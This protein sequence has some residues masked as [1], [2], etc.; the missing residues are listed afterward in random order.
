MYSDAKMN[1]VSQISKEIEQVYGIPKT[2]T[3]ML[4]LQTRLLAILDDSIGLRD[5]IQNKQVTI[6][7]SDLRGFTAIVEKQPPLAVIEVLNR[8]FHRMSQIILDYGG[9][10]DKFMGDAIMV[11][12]GAPTHAADDVERAIACAAEM[13]QAMNEINQ[14]NQ[15]HD[16][17]EL[18]M[19]IGINTGQVVAGRLGSNIHS[20]YTVIG[21]EV[22]L[23]SRVEAQSLRGQIL[24]SENTYVCAKDFIEI[25]D[26]N[27]VHVKGKSIPVKMYELL[28]TSRPRPIQVP[29]REI[30]RSPRVGVDMPVEF[31]KV[32]GKQVLSDQFLGRIVDLSYGGMLLISPV[33]LSLHAEIRF[34]FAISILGNGASDCYARVLRSNPFSDQFECSMEFSHIDKSAYYG[35]K[36]MVD[37]IVAE[38]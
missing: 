21:D 35:L 14:E 8:Y 30:R 17:P 33:E 9:T 37:S 32:S 19:G 23:A 5:T 28:A 25:G 20:E 13:Q 24:L 11:L 34:P 12:F 26:I 27:E 22:N 31:Q 38:L 4:G 29:I 18:Y 6:L 15:Q 1:L 7:L 36:N 3:N 10:I 2:D 16:F